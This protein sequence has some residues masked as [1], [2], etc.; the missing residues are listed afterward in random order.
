MFSFLKLKKYLRKFFENPKND[1]YLGIQGGR[2]QYYIL[3]SF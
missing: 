1:L 2:K 3:K